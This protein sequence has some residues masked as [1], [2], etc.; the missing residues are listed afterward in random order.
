[1]RRCH[2]GVHHCASLRAKKVEIYATPILTHFI[3]HGGIVLEPGKHLLCQ[4]GIDAFH[5]LSQRSLDT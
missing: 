5:T 2:V 4:V 3:D 1:M